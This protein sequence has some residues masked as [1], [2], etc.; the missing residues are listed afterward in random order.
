MKVDFVFKSQNQLS[1]FSLI[2][3]SCFGSV[4]GWNV[5]GGKKVTLSIA[6]SHCALVVFAGFYDDG[7]ITAHK[8]F[9]ASSFDVKT[10]LCT[11]VRVS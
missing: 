3:Y 11:V 6:K 4:V 10:M 2:F 8:Q 5:D 7:C 1:G 9:H